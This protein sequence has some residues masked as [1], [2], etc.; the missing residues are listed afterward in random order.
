MATSYVNF[1][2]LTDWSVVKMSVKTAKFG[3]GD[4]KSRKW[5]SSFSKIV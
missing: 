4:N 1:T 5:K 2:D 3:Q